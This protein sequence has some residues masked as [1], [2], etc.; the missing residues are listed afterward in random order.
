MNDLDELLEGL[1]AKQLLDVLS[2]VISLKNARTQCTPE[3]SSALP[4]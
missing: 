3:V 4:E 1:D 2:Y